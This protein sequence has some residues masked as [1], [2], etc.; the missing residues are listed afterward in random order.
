MMKSVICTWRIDW[1]RYQAGSNASQECQN[2][3]NTREKYEED[4]RSFGE[5]TLKSDN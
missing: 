4:A 5:T 3:I 1:D 2:E